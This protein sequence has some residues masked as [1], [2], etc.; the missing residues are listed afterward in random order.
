MEFMPGRCKLCRSTI[1]DEQ[2]ENEKTDAEE[3]KEGSREE[4]IRES[5][6]SNKNKENIMFNWIGKCEENKR[7]E[8]NLSNMIELAKGDLAYDRALGTMQNFQDKPK[9]MYDA[10]T[11]TDITQ[12]L[13][14]R[15]PRAVSEVTIDENGELA[16]EWE[17]AE[18]EENV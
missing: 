5:R 15:E 8:Q 7:I 10:K 6:K 12:T 2:V 1:A 13:N 16:I 17:T 14:E 4:S 3:T 9:G 18:E 11:L